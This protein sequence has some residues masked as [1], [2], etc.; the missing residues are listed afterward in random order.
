MECKDSHIIS[1]HVQ[2]PQ[3]SAFLESQI[4]FKFT[5]YLF[6]ECALQRAFEWFSCILDLKFAEIRQKW[7]TIQLVYRDF[8]VIIVDCLIIMGIGHQKN[9]CQLQIC[10]TN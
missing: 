7:Q 1:P 6:N 9:T 3:I 4:S 5:S 2:F 10:G 8:W